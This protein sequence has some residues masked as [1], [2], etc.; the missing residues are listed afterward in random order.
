MMNN[1]KT[2]K[3]KFIKT[4]QDLN[5]IDLNSIVEKLKNTNLSDIKNIDS[6]DIISYLKSSNYSKPIIGFLIFSSFIYFLLIPNIKSFNS[7]YKLSRQYI[8]ESQNL[9][10]LNNDLK[11][12]KNKYKKINSSMEEIKSSI[13][14]KDKLIYLTN[15][16]DDLSKSTSTRIDFFSPINKNKEDSICKISEAN[17]IYKNDLAKRYGSESSK[18]EI[19][20]AIYELKLFGNYLNIISFLNS[21]QNYDLMIIASCIQVNEENKD[22]LVDEGFVKANLILKLPTR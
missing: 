3:E 2:F 7:K 20:E 15:L 9:P 19:N 22:N 11:I 6:K 4:Y 1:F 14:E 21:I 8:K 10:T 16:F 13:I 5:N 12:I 18:K 17:Q